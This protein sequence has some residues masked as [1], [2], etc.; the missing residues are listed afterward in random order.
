[1]GFRAPRSCRFDITEHNVSFNGLPIALEGLRV[2]HISDLH[3]RSDQ[4]DTLLEAAV[5]QV[6]A[7]GAD[8]VVVTGDFVDGPARD[9]LP[10]CRIVARLQARH[11]VF[12]TLGNHDHRGNPA[13]LTRRLQDVGITVLTNRSIQWTPGFYVAG[14]DDLF[15]G[16]PDLAAA[17]AAVPQNAPV[18]LLSHDPSIL[19][20]L[21]QDRD[22]VVLSGHTHGGQM[23]FRFLPPRL[24]CRFHLGTEYVHGW[25]THGRVRMYVNRGIGVT[26]SRVFARR[27][28]CPPEIACFTLARSG[29]DGPKAGGQ[30]ERAAEL[31]ARIV[32]IIK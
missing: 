27:I 18:L 10:V 15:E 26:G 4:P 8:F 19:D 2:V 7:L 24:V 32:R 16:N 23:V 9:I 5:E 20:R 31:S 11:G 21:P 1:M 29:E 14:V 12:A 30:R 22:L 6:N 3:R 25:F 17:R 13:E 28:N